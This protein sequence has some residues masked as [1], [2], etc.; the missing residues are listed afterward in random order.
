MASLS[1]GPVSAEGRPGY[2]VDA[3]AH[4]RAQ[5]AISSGTIS[6]ER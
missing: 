1:K 2:L 4:R 3:R 6:P 5:A